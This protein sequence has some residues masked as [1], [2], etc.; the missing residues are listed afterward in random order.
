M[1]FEDRTANPEQPPKK[2]I[3]LS[4]CRRWPTHRLCVLRLEEEIAIASDTVIQLIKTKLR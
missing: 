4:C 1:H 3:S 2:G